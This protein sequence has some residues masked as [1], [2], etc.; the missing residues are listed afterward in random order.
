MNDLFIKMQLI[1]YGIV[2]TNWHEMFM[3]SPLWVA[4]FA[5]KIGES[6]GIKHVELLREY[7]TIILT[8]DGSDTEYVK[9]R[10]HELDMQILEVKTELDKNEDVYH[11]FLL[12]LKCVNSAVA[13]NN[14]FYGENDALRSFEYGLLCL[15]SCRELVLRNLDPEKDSL[16]Q[17][18][19][20]EVTDP[21]IHPVRWNTVDS[22]VKDLCN[23]SVMRFWGPN[24]ATVD[25]TRTMRVGAK[26]NHMIVSWLYSN[27]MSYADKTTYKVRFPSG[28][29]RLVH[30]D[31]FNVTIGTIG[32]LNKPS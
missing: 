31:G 29:V 25:S 12:M 9:K 30:F 16:F 1:S 6:L 23:A 18:W 10:V 13:S 20:Q 8:N 26:Y 28:A 2:D 7:L 17:N 5:I 15:I 22:F 4:G 3:R 11:P 14:A 21:S 27:G 32:K 24:E 19:R